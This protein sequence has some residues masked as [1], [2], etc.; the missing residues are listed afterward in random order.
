[1]FGFRWSRFLSGSGEGAEVPAVWFSSLPELATEH[2]LLRPLVMRDA[3]DIFAYA[4]DPEVARYV[5][6]DPHTSLADTR[7]YIRYMRGL[8]RRGLPSSWGVELRETG[9]VIGTVGF[10]WYSSQNLSAEVG[11]S[12]AREHWNRGYATEALRAALCSAFASIPLNRV[13]AQHDVRNP[14][15]GRVME[16]CG[17]KMEGVLRQRIKNKGELADVALWAILRSDLE[18]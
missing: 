9:R 3:R 6:W 2:L 1:M 12:F 4:S 14:A 8:Y 10:M 5:L 18:D 7:S 11:Y 15:S 16:K 13:E 17:M